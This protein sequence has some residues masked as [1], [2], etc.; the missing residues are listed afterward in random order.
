[1]H[2]FHDCLAL[3][4]RTVTRWINTTPLSSEDVLLR[5]IYWSHNLVICLTRKCQKSTFDKG[6]RLVFYSLQIVLTLTSHFRQH[7]W[8]PLNSKLLNNIK[9]WRV[10][11]KGIC[12]CPCP[13]TRFPPPVFLCLF[14]FLFFCYS[15]I[16]DK[17]DRRFSNAK[18]TYFGNSRNPRVSSEQ[19]C[20]R[21]ITE[22]E[23]SLEGKVEFKRNL[24]ITYSR[25][26]S[27]KMATSG[28]LE[29]Q[30]SG[31]ESAIFKQTIRERTGI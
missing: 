17:L 13:V 3:H 7:Y 30:S 21:S 16:F 11:S 22:L 6:I 28:S 12:F 27:G 9:R 24:R 10:V 2:A 19:S 4:R 23:S 20:S 1:M 8:L 18:F 31:R 29:R 5:D 15:N 26:L 14:S 25:P